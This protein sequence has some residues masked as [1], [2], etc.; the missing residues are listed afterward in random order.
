MPWHSSHFL[1]LFDSIEEP[2]RTVLKYAT[3]AI[4]SL[5]GVFGQRLISMSK[6]GGSMMLAKILATFASMLSTISAS[7][8]TRI[9]MPVLREHSEAAH[10]IAQINVKIK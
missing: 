9:E 10:I 5:L 8:L 7:M 4:L 1:R 6:Q 3:G 2:I